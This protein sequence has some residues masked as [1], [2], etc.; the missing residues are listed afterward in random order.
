MSA[1]E[2]ALFEHSTVPLRQSYRM[3]FQRLATGLQVTMQNMERAMCK[4]QGAED[5]V[6]RN[7]CGAAGV[8]KRQCLE[9]EEGYSVR[10]QICWSLKKVVKA[11]DTGQ[12]ALSLENRYGRMLAEL[13]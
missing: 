4:V 12:T 9:R 10:D 6:E 5:K 2:T 7:E 8:K 1:T 11:T 13:F 3:T